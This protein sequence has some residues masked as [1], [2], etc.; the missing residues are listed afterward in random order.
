MEETMEMEKEDE[1]TSQG[2]GFTDDTVNAAGGE[3][4]YSSG[5]EYD[6]QV[7]SPSL[8]LNPRVVRA[9]HRHRPVEEPPHKG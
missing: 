5:D 8:I 9:E 1:P 7:S 6:N 4:S 3:D 2:F